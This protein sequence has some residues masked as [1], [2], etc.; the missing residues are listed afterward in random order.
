MCFATFATFAASALGTLDADF[1]ASF[2]ALAGLP[3]AF[4][5]FF[6]PAIA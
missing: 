2:V 6:V 5:V 1:V 4:F 3:G